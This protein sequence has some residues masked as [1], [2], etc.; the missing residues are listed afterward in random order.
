[1]RLAAVTPRRSYGFALLELL[2]VIVIVALLLVLTLPSYQQ[3]LMSMRRALAGAALMDA[4]MRQEQF[5]IE[6]KR[7]AQRLTDLDYPA[8]PY[9]ID[10]EGRVVSDQAEDRTYLIALEAA[11]NS[12]SLS[13]TPQLVQAADS[14]C[15]TLSLDST[16]TRRA[17]G[18]R[19]A[20]ECW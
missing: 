20:R 15:G 8:H 14:L 16:G 2:V 11:G 4:M 9:A 5:F 3:H 1:M 13:A 17:S 12:Y 18:A 7:Y 19:P 6:H 10:R